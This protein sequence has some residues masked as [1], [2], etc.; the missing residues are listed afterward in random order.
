MIEPRPHAFQTENHLIDDNTYWTLVGKGGWEDARN[1]LDPGPLWDNTSSSY[2]GLH[3]RVSEQA[4]APAQ[5][6]LRLV[7]VQ[8]FVVNVV[9]EGE[10]FG[11]RKRR[12]RGQ[13]SRNG[14]HHHL[15]ITDPVMERRYFAGQNGS[16]QVGH[17]ILCISLG[18]PYQGYAYKLIAGVILPPPEV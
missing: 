16:F 6:S 13:F 3:D 4:A 18:E 9:V 12:V 2:N 17:A 11:N 10:E 1:A 5:G 7:E 15:S 14:V 8:D